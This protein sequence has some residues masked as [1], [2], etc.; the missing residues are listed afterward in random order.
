MSEVEAQQGSD[1]SAINEALKT[2]C[3]EYGVERDRMSVLQIATLL[4]RLS[5]EET[6]DAEDLIRIAREELMAGFDFSS[7]AGD[8]LS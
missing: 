6:L 5:K 8:L 3:R 7:G 4:M 2:L 1:V